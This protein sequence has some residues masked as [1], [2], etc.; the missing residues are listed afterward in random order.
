MSQVTHKRGDTL[1]LSWSW[2]DEAGTAIDLTDCT[3]RLQVRSKR[4][5]LLASADTDDGLTIADPETGAVNLLID[6]E[7]MSA[8]PLGSHSMDLEITFADG[9]VK[10]TETVKLKIIEDITR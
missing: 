1:S 6:A 5:E 10:S 7:T 8:V 4:G 9:T 2:K 3:A